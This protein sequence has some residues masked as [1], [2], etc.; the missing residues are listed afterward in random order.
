M[1]SKMAKLID[2]KSIVTITLTAVFAY[3]A[4]TGRITGDN[5]MTVFSTVIA[6]FFGTKYQKNQIGLDEQDEKRYKASKGE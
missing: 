6:F 2:V 1:G 4:V 3:L 5:F